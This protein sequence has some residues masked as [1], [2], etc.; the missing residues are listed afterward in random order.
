MLM[1]AARKREFVNAIV[2]LA[3][4][5]PHGRVTNYGTLAR[6]A[7][8]PAMSRMVGMVLAGRYGQVSGLPAHRVTASGGR[9]SGAGAFA[10]GEM[11]QMLRAEG[12]EIRRGKVVDY[13]RYFWDPLKELVL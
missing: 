2:Q 12:V 9:L 11:E 8:Y 3:A 13:T 10:P 6:A 7:G 4:L 1:D 5:I